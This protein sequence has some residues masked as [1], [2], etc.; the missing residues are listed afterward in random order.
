MQLK[1]E[2]QSITSLNK[3]EMATIH[4]GGEKRSDRRTGDCAFSRRHGVTTAT[5]NGE[6]VAT[7]CY[8]KCTCINP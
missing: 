4:G 3:Q 7:G 5:I 8:P 2:K 6:T 1:L